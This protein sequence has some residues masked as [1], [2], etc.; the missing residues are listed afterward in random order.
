MHNP[1][2]LNLNWNYAKEVVPFE[3][4]LSDELMNMRTAKTQLLTKSGK[5][6]ESTDWVSYP[7]HLGLHAIEVQKHL[8]DEVQ[9]HSNAVVIV[10]IGGSLLGAKAIYEALTHTY[11]L[12]NAKKFHPTPLLF[13]AGHHLSQDE[14]IELCEVLDGYSPSL[15]V[16]SKSGGT[17]EPALAFRILKQYFDKRFSVPEC[18]KRIF[19]ITDEHEGSL[20]SLA[21]QNHY[22][23]FAIPRG[24]GGRYSVFTSVG[25]FPLALAGIPV[26]EFMKGACHAQEI[27]THPDYNDFGNNPAILYAAIRNILYKNNYKIEALCTWTPKV[28]GVSEWWKQ[29]FGESDGKDGT[30]IFPA[31]A[32][33]TTDL[34]SLGQYFQDGE[35]HLFSTH[36]KFHEHHLLKIPSSQLADGFDF[37]VGKDYSFAQEKAQEGTFL[38][39]THGKM[40]ILLW[41]IPTLNAYWLG[42]W[43]YTNMFACGLGGYARG[44]NPFNQPGVENYKN[45]MFS[46]MGKPGFERKNHG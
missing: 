44:I 8:V 10:G 43:M 24:I 16:I 5:S 2:E 38:A 25:L 18:Q 39:H 34:H 36:L 29:L 14:L 9:K 37:L 1:S 4:Y 22:S 31:S 17:T 21:K 41:E 3:K 27:C 46:L 13:W 6:S 32:N 42:A 45:N 35:R 23:T 12:S 33:F 11:A 19:A 7:K 30:G 20:L 28:K 40:P 26:L 15:V